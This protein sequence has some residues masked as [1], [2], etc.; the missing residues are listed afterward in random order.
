MVVQ[1]GFHS[2]LCFWYAKDHFS[3]AGLLYFFLVDFY[4]NAVELRVGLGDEFCFREVE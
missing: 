2:F 3:L 1:E 4:Q